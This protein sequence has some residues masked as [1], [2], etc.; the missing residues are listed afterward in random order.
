[1]IVI[2]CVALLVAALIAVICLV[3]SS[4]ALA[5][6]GWLQHLRFV[7][8]R[9]GLRRIMTDLAELSEA[10]SEVSPATACS[11]HRTSLRVEKSWL[12]AI[13]L[14]ISPGG[15]SKA[16]NVWQDEHLMINHLYL[17]AD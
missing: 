5:R 11:R 4:D 3:L 6:M 10:I 15:Y 16:D 7:R 13:G 1:M 9:T 12:A 14:P 2:V 8:G 17:Q